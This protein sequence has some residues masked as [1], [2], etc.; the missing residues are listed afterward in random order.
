MTRFFS[1][2]NGGVVFISDENNQVKKYRPGKLNEDLSDI[3]YSI[4]SK[5]VLFK[6][7]DR[8]ENE[9]VMG[10]EH[11]HLDFRTMI[12][13]E[14]YE[15]ETIIYSATAVKYN[16]PIG[17]VYFFFVKPFHRLMIKVILGNI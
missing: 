8:N 4:G 15:G 14:R 17:K 6:V 5:S 11:K 13:V 3:H 10:E 16:K 1:K 9:I 2:T 12:F 7:I